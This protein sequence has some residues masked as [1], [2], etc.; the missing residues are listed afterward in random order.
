MRYT[1]QKKFS[2]SWRGMIAAQMQGMNGH[3]NAPCKGGTT[4]QGMVIVVELGLL[5]RGGRGECRSY[6]AQSAFVC[7]YPGFHFG[8]CPHCTLGFE[9]VSC[10]RHS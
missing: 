5:F 7:A 9:G 10:L 2:Y 3:S 8:L 4:A 1:V 6:G